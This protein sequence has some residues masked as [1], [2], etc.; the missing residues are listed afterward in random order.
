MARNMGLIQGDKLDLAEEGYYTWFRDKCRSLMQ[1]DGVNYFKW[2]R[3]GSGASPHFMAL[4]NIARELRQVDPDLFINVTVG[5]WP[6]PFWLNHVDST[7]RGDGGDVGWLGK[8]D[9]REQWLTFRDHYC[10][11]NVVTRAPLYPLNSIM[12][13]GIVHGRHFQGTR[14]SKAGSDLKNEARSYFGAGPTLQEL[15]LTPSMMSEESWQQVGEAASWAQNNAD[16]LLDSHW[17]GD[18]PLKMLP[19]GYASWSPRKGIITLRN[20]D[21]Q[22]H[23]YVLDIERVFELPAEAPRRY[24]LKNAYP[25]QTADEVTLTAG[26]THTLTLK[27]FEVLVLEAEPVVP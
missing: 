6:S 21:D 10:Y 7:W 24:Q 1:Y 9:D 19:Y 26:D 3:A 12:H 5:T 27:P 22:P 8:G 4:L 16:V 2:D 13:H 14:V 18:D 11:R 25:D 15:Y 17:F 20:P 23:T